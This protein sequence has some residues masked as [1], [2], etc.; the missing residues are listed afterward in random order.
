[1]YTPQGPFPLAHHFESTLATLVTLGAKAMQ[2][3]TYIHV[4]EWLTYIPP[5]IP[6]W[7]TWKFI[8]E[9]IALLTEIGIFILMIQKRREAA[10]RHEKHRQQQLLRERRSYKDNRGKNGHEEWLREQLEWEELMREEREYEEFE[11]GLRAH[12]ER[13]RQRRRN[14]ER[15]EDRRLYVSAISSASMGVAGGRERDE[16]A[17]AG[18]DVKDTCVLQ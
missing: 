14:R 9:H 8:L 2:W 13:K 1:M 10:E 12:D 7:L 15:R 6:A 5:P 11:R 17:G 16:G 4:P 18:P 3:L